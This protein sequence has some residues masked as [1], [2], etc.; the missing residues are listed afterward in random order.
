MIK[1]LYGKDKK[2][3]YKFWQI[4]V[5]ETHGVVE[6]L[7]LHGQ[8]GGE[9]TPKRE[10]I[11]KG[12]QGRTLFEQGVSEAEGRIKKQIDKGYRENKDELDDLPL[13]AMLAGDYNKIGHRVEYSLGVDLSDKLDGVRCL[14]K[15]PELGI[16]TLESRTGQPYE[17]PHIRD[18]LAL[19]M[20]PG[21]VRDG[22]FY[23]HGQ[24][25]Q[26]I[27]SA[28]KRTN[29]QEAIDKAKR[30][31]EKASKMETDSK[32][33]TDDWY[34]F[35]M[36]AE[37]EL[38]E[39]ELIHSIRPQLQFIVFDIPSVKPWHERLEDLKASST[40]QQG[41]VRV[42]QYTRVYSEEAMKLAH[43]DAVARGFEGIMLR[44]RNGLYESGKRSADLQKYKE[45]IDSEFL[46]L[47]IIPDKEDGSIFVLQNDI[48]GDIFTCVMGTMLERA[49]YL[50]HKVDYVGKMLTVKYQSR[51][52]KTLLPQFPTGVVFREGVFVDGEFVPTE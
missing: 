2:G 49:K 45:F 52:K 28:V 44:N 24:A 47:D 20:V 11:P 9:L 7:I 4:S 31:L 25:L 26:D 10:N 23:L 40:L 51:Y 17:L 32:V 5:S 19:L 16:V 15:C 35:N 6:L 33:S 39:A 42:L 43:K 14:A 12:K 38:K 22:E 8:E 50:L 27:T 18:E 1:T 30:K 41:F 37:A 48:T 3:K 21:E 29:T 13:L 46:I 36:E 34:T